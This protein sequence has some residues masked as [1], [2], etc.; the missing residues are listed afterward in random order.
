MVVPLIQLL[1]PLACQAGPGVLVTNRKPRRGGMLCVHLTY[2][3]R[4]SRKALFTWTLT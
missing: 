2:L 1:G 4:D 3:V